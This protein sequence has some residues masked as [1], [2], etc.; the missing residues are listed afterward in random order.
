MIKF[1]LIPTNLDHDPLNWHFK[2]T[3]MGAHYITL[4]RVF[5]C[6]PIM[7]RNPELFIKLGEEKEYSSCQQ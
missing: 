6:V 7:C 4:L 5:K 1:V 2:M 3:V